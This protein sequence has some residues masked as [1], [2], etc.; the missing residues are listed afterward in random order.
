MGREEVSSGS[1][2]ERKKEETKKKIINVAIDL[3]KQLGVNATTMEQIAREADIAKG[4]LY[5]YFPVK[6]AII[7]EYIKR[8]SMEKNSDRISRLAKLP[9]TRSRLTASFGELIRGVQAQKEIFE[10]YLVY[11]MKNTI[12]F[13]KDAGEKSGIELLAAEIIKLGQE[14]SEIRQDLPLEIMI[15][16]FVFAFIEVAK[17]FYIDPDRFNASEVI[18]QCIDLFMDGAK[19]RGN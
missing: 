2:V 15:D 4:T 18:E 3:F 10:N 14:S 16:L 7:D 1:R 9:D 6:E 5:N 12:S 17:Q 19:V 8:L 13:N 11:Q